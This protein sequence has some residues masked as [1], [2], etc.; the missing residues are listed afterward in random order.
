M[1]IVFAC[2]VSLGR[3]K[4]YLWYNSKLSGKVLAI[5]ENYAN[6]DY[7]GVIDITLRLRYE[8]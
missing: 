4:C 7:S 1:S 2:F 3:L 6:R 8:V 5:E